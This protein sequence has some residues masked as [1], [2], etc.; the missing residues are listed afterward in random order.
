M[1][2]DTRT[3]L[4]V[5]AVAVSEASRLL[6]LSEFTVRAYVRRGVLPSIRLGRRILIPVSALM[7]VIR[8]KQEAHNTD[9]S[10]VADK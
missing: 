9:D 3:E 2:T 4:Q 1:H 6:S 7:E 5:L 8:R 10:S